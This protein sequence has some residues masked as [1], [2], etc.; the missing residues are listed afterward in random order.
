[1]NIQKVITSF[2]VIL[3]LPLI[4]LVLILFWPL[5]LAWYIGDIFVE[6]EMLVFITGF[7]L[8]I[9]YLFFITYYVSLI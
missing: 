1:M 5:G 8:E 3:T 2:Y 4:I 7:S 9:A 6:N